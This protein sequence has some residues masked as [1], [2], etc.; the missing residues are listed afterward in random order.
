MS[1]KAALQN[2]PISMSNLIK[3][4]RQSGSRALTLQQ[5]KSMIDSQLLAQ[6][7]SKND[8]MNDYTKSHLEAYKKKLKMFDKAAHKN[9]M[10]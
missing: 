5:I 7:Q 3:M 10:D 8:L 4:Q 9:S 2:F 1:P 6:S